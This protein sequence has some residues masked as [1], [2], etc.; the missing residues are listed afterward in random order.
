MSLYSGPDLS[1]GPVSLCLP[2]PP[3]I[4]RAYIAPDVAEAV[5]LWLMQA[6]AGS[7]TLYFAIRVDGMLAGQIFLYD[8]SAQSTAAQVGLH[9]FDPAMRGRGIGAAALALLQDYVAKQTVLKSLDFVAATNH[10]AAVHAARKC[11]FNPAGPSR[12]NSQEMVYTWK[13]PQH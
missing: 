13:V 4:E 12:K 2:D 3:E 8:L 7:D 11:G 6:M 1:L 5:R 9:L 10:V